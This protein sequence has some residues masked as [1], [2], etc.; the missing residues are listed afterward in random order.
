MEPTLLSER[1][2]R[3]ADRSAPPPRADLAQAVA[4][5]LTGSAVLLAL[6]LA[7]IAVAV[8]RPRPVPAPRLLEVAR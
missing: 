7:V 5:A 1:L 6:G 2:T 4:T 8:R 3:L